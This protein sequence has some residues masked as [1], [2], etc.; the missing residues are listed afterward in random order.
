MLEFSKKIT[1][2]IHLFTNFFQKKRCFSQIPQNDQFLNFGVLRPCSSQ[3]PVRYRLYPKIVSYRPYIAPSLFLTIS[4][5]F[6]PNMTCLLQQNQKLR[7]LTKNQTFG[8][9][10]GTTIV[11]QPLGERAKNVVRDF[12]KD[13]ELRKVE[14]RKLKNETVYLLRRYFTIFQKF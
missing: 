14:K 11:C 6:S 1:K 9:P 7:H 5:L 2:Q 13:F 3:A 8:A 12:K 4:K 10:G